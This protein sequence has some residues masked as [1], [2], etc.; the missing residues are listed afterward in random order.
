MSSMWKVFHKKWLTR[1]IEREH[2][3]FE[4]NVLGNSSANNINN[5]IRNEICSSP[6]QPKIDKNKNVNNPIV[7]TYENHA[8]VV[9][10]P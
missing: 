8:Y 3:S 5:T 1:Y 6:Q 4:P 9:I 7:S 10:G 2:Q